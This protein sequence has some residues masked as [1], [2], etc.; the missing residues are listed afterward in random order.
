MTGFTVA[1]VT[2]FIGAFA[3][4]VPMLCATYALAG[5]TYNDYTGSFLAAVD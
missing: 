1:G 5:K 4:S 3:N 2:I